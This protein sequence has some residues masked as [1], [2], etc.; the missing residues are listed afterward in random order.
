MNIVHIALQGCLRGRNVDFGVTAD[1]GGHI[2]Y[3]L[4]HANAVIEADSSTAITIVTRRFEAPFATYGAVPIERVSPRLRIVRLPSELRGYRTMAELTAELPSLQESFLA[5][6]RTEPLPDLIHAHYSEAAVLAQVAKIHF[7][8]PYV[9]TPHSYGR[10]SVDASGQTDAVLAARIAREDAAL[11]EADLVTASSVHEAE[12]QA[13]QSP[14]YRP[15]CVAVLP[16][17]V[18]IDAFTLPDVP[19]ELD[20][21][22]SRTLRDPDRPTV[23][24]VA[25]PVRKKNLVSVL[26]AFR[27]S[28]RLRTVA[29]VIVIAGTRDHND[30]LEP[31]ARAVLAELLVAAT[32]PDLK[33]IVSIPRHYG[34]REIPAIYRWARDRGGVFVSPARSEPFG[35]TLL[36]AAASGLPVVGTT[37]GAPPEIVQRLGNGAVVDPDDVIALATEIERMFDNRALWSYRSANGCRA[38]RALTWKHHATSYLSL[39]RGIVS[40]AVMSPPRPE[41]RLL[42]CDVDGTLTG[43]P[44]A[45]ARFARWLALESSVRF[46]IATGRRFYDAL[47]ILRLA[48]LPRP[49]VVIASVGTEVYWRNADGATYREDENWSTR[50]AWRWPRDAIVRLLAGVD[51]LQP[52]P[53]GAQRPRKLGYLTA[54]SGVVDKIATVLADLDHTLIWSHGR[55]VDVL[56]GGVSKASAVEYVADQLGFDAA[57]II[58]AGDSGNDRSMLTHATH[59]I[60]VS[61]AIDN[62][63]YDPALAHAYVSEAAF[64]DG[65]IEGVMRVLAGRAA[66]TAVRRA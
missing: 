21:R 33:G 15:G 59:A 7:G 12:N 19:A 45:S 14:T 2:R 58:V 40:L 62:L 44:A 24:A 64:A 66:E 29:N 6:L 60:L 57:N 16:P 34:S 48:G 8:I 10:V 23:L 30:N 56:P 26:R 37:V 46:A 51:G 20:E 13:A 18:D 32:A 38:V 36:E 17:G 9:Y 42:V 31:E 25:R 53:N 11:A 55:F 28:P 49:E 39:V 65:V 47:E 50:H 54:D 61:N 35:L 5:W 27:A 43:D 4:D 41:E 22:L 3:V 1:T 52:Q 63:S